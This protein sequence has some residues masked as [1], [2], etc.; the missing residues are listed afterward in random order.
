[1]CNQCNVEYEMAI[2]KWKIIINKC[3]PQHIKWNIYLYFNCREW[4]KSVRTLTNPTCLS[5]MQKRNKTIDFATEVKIHKIKSIN[6]QNR[7]E[8]K[9]NDRMKA[10]KTVVSQRS[11][12]DSSARY[13]YSR[14]F[15]LFDNNAFVQILKFVFDALQI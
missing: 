14:A 12:D 7:D 9:W 1:M 5:A 10:A 15:A 6:K 2:T 13:S 11:V 3:L 4:W 8:M